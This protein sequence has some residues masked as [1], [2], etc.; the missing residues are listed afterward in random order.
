MNNNNL[1]YLLFCMA[2]EP[3]N[4]FCT[5][6]KQEVMWF[7]YHLSYKS[8]SYIDT[9]VLTLCAQRQCHMSLRKP[10]KASLWPF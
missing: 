5:H 10:Q 3:C 8:P 7:V 2:F 4:T 6:A 1:T 9:V